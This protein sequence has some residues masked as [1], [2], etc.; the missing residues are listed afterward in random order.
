M[1]EI[2]EMHNI[3][4][5][6]YEIRGV[7]V[8]LDFDLAKLYECKNGT[9]TINLAVKRHI[10]RFPKRFMFQLTIEECNMISRF[11]TETLKKQGYNIKYLPYAFTEQGVA[12]IA[13]VLRTKVAE[14]VSIRIMDAFVNMRHLIIENKNIYKSIDIINNKLV[15]HDK[16]FE[17]LFS[18][19]DK[20][21]QLFLKGEEY[22]AYSSFIS[23]F[24]EA[25][26]ELI[27]VDSYADNTFLDIIR[28]FKCHVILI[29]KNSDRLT[30]MD[31]SKYNKQYNNLKVIRNND[32]HD[33]YFIVDKKEIYQSGTSIN[34]AGEK[35][36][37]INII[38]DVFMKK[39]L[40]E[41]INSLINKTN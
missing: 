17:Y 27:V 13:T 19:F 25:N 14:E 11:Q 10:N 26:K 33:R 2:V 39:R 12:M 22:D 4:N 34:N 20:H 37:S 31:I 21:E 8:M 18:K 29:T 40:I 41:Y 15:E 24:K 3:E 7:Q 30:D 28:K 9:K 23:V 5:M 35:I 36:F 16:N 6:V 32:F 1:D 38:G